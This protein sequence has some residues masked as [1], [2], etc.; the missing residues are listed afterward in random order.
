MWEME[1]R[2]R[3]VDNQEQEGRDNNEII[4]SYYYTATKTF[5]ILR[6]CCLS[7]KIIQEN[8]RSI[9]ERY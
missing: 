2:S 6:L 8:I 5:L 9:V 4:L 3:D 1:L 7:Y